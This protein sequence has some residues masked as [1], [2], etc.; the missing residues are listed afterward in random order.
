LI[1][2]LLAPF[3]LVHALRHRHNTPPGLYA[4]KA[5]GGIF[6]KEQ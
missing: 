1:S 3:P 6:L 4:I 2:F 5:K